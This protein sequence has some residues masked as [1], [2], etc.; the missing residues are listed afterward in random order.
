MSAFGEITATPSP[1]GTTVVIT[2][3]LVGDRTATG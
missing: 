2:S 1:D 3:D